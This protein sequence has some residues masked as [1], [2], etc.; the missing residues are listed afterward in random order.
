[1][2][3]SKTTGGFYDPEIHGEAV[4]SDCVEIS[5]EAHAEL[6]AEQSSGK[7]IVSDKKGLPQ[8]VTPAA[9]V[10]TWDT[11]RSQRNALLSASDWTQLADAPVNKPAWATYR[12]ALRDITETFAT[13]DAVVWPTKPE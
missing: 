13:P 8:A 2:L 4:P 9:P 7:V 11:V 6:L 5:K 1:M 10:L 3:Y 12:E